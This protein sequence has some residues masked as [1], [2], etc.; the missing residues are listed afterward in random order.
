MLI[1]AYAWRQKKTGLR[2]KALDMATYV[3]IMATSLVRKEMAMH[4]KL[5]PLSDK[6][7]EIMDVVWDLGRASVF[8]VRDVLALQREVARNTVRTMMERLEERGWLTHDVIGR[9][10]F[11]SAV[12]PRH[13]SVGQRIVHVLD[14][15]CGGNP[16]HLMSALLEHRGLSDDEIER[17]ERMLASAKKHAAKQPKTKRRS[18]NL[19]KPKGK[20]S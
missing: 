3:A 6:Q 13:V 16:E 8:E 10:Y 7:R 18:N 11:Y 17:I 19:R 15:A 14:K 2:K 5:E 12:V 1:S 4:K 20:Q 9:T